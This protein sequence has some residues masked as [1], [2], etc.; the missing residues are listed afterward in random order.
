MPADLTL[1]LAFDKAWSQQLRVRRHDWIWGPSQ[2]NCSTKLKLKIQRI[3]TSELFWCVLFFSEW[4]WYGMVQLKLTRG[5]STPPPSMP[6]TLSYSQSHHGL[7]QDPPWMVA[8]CR[9]AAK[10]KMP[11]LWEACWCPVTSQRAMIGTF[12]SNPHMPRT[13]LTSKNTGMNGL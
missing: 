2:S 10:K 1:K 6:P 12:I 5:H 8:G 11:W 3:S 4:E 9:W 13:Q 7:G